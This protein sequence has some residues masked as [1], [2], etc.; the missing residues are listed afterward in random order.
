MNLHTSSV[1]ALA[2]RCVCLAL[3]LLLCRSSAGDDKKEYWRE[4]NAAVVQQHNLKNRDR[5][6]PQ[7]DVPLWLDPGQTYERDDLPVIQMAPG[8]KASVAWGEGAMLELLEMEPGSQYPHQELNEELLILGQKGSA[9]CTFDGQEV[10]LRKDELLYLTPNTK[11]TLQAGEEGWQAIEVFAPVRADHLRLVGIEIPAGGS[12]GYPDQG[13]TPSIDPGKVIN[14]HEIQWAGLTPADTH[15]SYRRSG[16]GS[17]LVWGRNAMLSLIRMDA[18]TSFPLHI[19]PEDQLMIAL[20]GSL[21]EGLMD[22]AY[23]MNGQAQHVVLQPGGMAHSA[24][25]G[26][27]G[28]DALDVFWPVRPDY[29]TKF[30]EQQ[31]LYEEVI[32]PGTKP[33]KLAEGFTFSE[34]PTWLKGALYFSDMYFEDHRQGNWTGSAQR[35]RLIRMEPDGKW[36]VLSNGMQTNG[37]IASSA[38]NLLVCDMFGHRVIELDPRTGEVLDVV[39]DRVD[40]KPIDGPNDLVMDAR[41][42]IY[43]SDPQFTPETE[44]SQAGKQ[45][46]YVP[47]NGPPRVVIRPGD[48]AMPNGVEI[49]PDGKT[50][51]V[52]NTWFQPGENFVWAYDIQPDGSLTHQRK[53]AA[54]NL[55]PEVMSDERPEYRFDS[56]AD[57]M[58]VD[59][60]GRLYV[61]T[62]SGV[63][64]F[65]PSGI[66]VGTIW[67]PQYPVS[68]AFGGAKGDILYLVGESSVWSI[69]TKVSGFRVPRGL[70]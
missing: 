66:Y 29:I 3:A 45:V 42:G 54:L 57:G 60:D 23:E 4:R 30:Q 61:C 34:G 39:C 43:V 33:I 2:K 63:Q 68:C 31:A 55:T 25:L 56:R 7:T 59:M 27:H 69:Q 21:L 67:C 28:A 70:D 11:R 14:V 47:A 20:R 26:E 44:K 19:H 24:V 16:A 52:N 46:Y 40:D 53:F 49:S 9:K 17:R 51:Y 64:I 13:V 41:G 38:G 32:A 37:T 65:A 5:V 10:T 18:N 1:C 36:Q 35:S 48:Y 12:V 15:Q 62:L 8:V 58:A 6:I 50:F 22:Y